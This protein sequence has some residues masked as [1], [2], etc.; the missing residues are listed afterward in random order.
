MNLF[1][2]FCLVGL[3]VVSLVF[4]VL[5][6]VLFKPDDRIAVQ[7][8]RF[9]GCAAVLSLAAIWIGLAAKLINSFFN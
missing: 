1:H 3:F 9:M 2:L 6:C 5:V 7:F 8:V 4:I